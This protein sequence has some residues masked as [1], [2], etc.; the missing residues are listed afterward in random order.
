MFSRW[1]V[2]VYGQSH[3]VPHT[4]KACANDLDNVAIVAFPGVSGN[5]LEAFKEGL[6]P[7]SLEILKEEL[8][9]SRRGFKTAIIDKLEKTAATWSPSGQCLAYNIDTLLHKKSDRMFSSVGYIEINGNVVVASDIFP[10]TKYGYNKRHFNVSTLKYPPFVK[11]EDVNGTT[12]YKGFCMD[13]LRELSNKLNF[14]YTITEPVDGK[15]GAYEDRNKTFNG[16]V[17]Q[18]QREEVDMVAAPLST[19]SDRTPVMDFSYPFYYE[20]TTVILKKPDVNATK[21]RTLI[22]PFKWEVLVSIGL[23][24]P[25]MTMLAFLIEK[26]NPFY[27]KSEHSD[28]RE[29]NGGLHRLH[30]SVWYMYGALLCQGGVH[31]PDSTAGRTLVSSWWLFCII[32]VGIYSGNLIA[33]LT[34]TKEKPPFDTL[35]EMI[36]LKGS[37]RWGTLSDTH[38]AAVFLNS[39]NPTYKPIG[40]GIRDFN[41]T[42][43]DVLSTDPEVH[44]RKVKKGKYA[45]IGDKTYIETAMAEECSLTSINEEFLPLKYGLGFVKNSPHTAIFSKQL[46]KLHEGGLFQIWKRKWWPK[47]NFCA[48]NTV[49][50]AKP[51]SLMDVQSAFYVCLIGVFLG[52]VAFIIELLVHRCRLRNSELCNRQSITRKPSTESTRANDSKYTEGEGEIHI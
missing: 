35:S 37:Y 31:L 9:G 50:E 20:Y 5:G 7:M 12:D 1:L 22:D 8:L 41:K 47:A 30:N 16:L 11:K 44:I 27:E 18:L 14:T 26:Y 46:I 33:F 38:F 29:R 39:D 15:W 42:D 40:D 51:I 43:P 49:T 6:E 32:I 19:T 24:L 45:W 23:A 48:R 10:N 13:L 52:S 17:G 2:V 28:E 3:G 25:V 36:K 21:W 4:L 34:V